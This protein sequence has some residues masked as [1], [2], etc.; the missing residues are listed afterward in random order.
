MIEAASAADTKNNGAHYYVA[1]TEADI[2][3]ANALTLD[4]ATGALAVEL[5]FENPNSPAIQTAVRSRLLRST[6]E[7]FRTTGNVDGAYFINANTQEGRSRY[8]TLLAGSANGDSASSPENNDAATYTVYGLIPLQDATHGAS[9]QG[10]TE[11]IRNEQWKARGFRSAEMQHFASL[12][13]HRIQ[14]ILQAGGGQVGVL[15]FK[16]KEGAP[17]TTAP[18]EVSPPQFAEVQVEEG[19]VA[20]YKDAPVAERQLEHAA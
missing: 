19:A 13:L 1:P 14:A 4:E 5:K 3:H 2:A 8:Q 11:F 15:H 16:R 7:L 10:A 9:L 17:K 12:S 6:G 18:A 20:G